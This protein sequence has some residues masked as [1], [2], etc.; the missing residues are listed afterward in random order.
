MTSTTTTTATAQFNPDRY[1][2]M[3]YRRCG[4]SGLMLPAFSIGGWHNFTDRDNVVEMMTAAFDLGITHVDLANN[5]G[6]PPGE[7]ETQVGDVLRREFKGHRDELIISSKAGYRMWPGPYGDLGSKK[8]LI[9]SLDQSLQR[10]GLEYVDIFYHHRFDPHTPL[11]ETMGALDLIVKQGKALYVGVSNYRGPAI[12]E[13]HHQLQQRGTALTIHQPSYSMFNRTPEHDV[14]PHTGR[15]GVGV[16]AFSP[17]AQ[18][19][20]SDKYLDD[21]PAD[22]RAAS[23]TGFLQRDRITPELQVQLHKLN[24]VARERGQSLSQMAL[25]WL[26]RDERVTSVLFGASRVSQIEANVKSLDAAAFSAEELEK[27]DAILAE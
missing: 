4:R 15:L 23:P 9:A 17:L 5:Y 1:Q 18:G 10:L 3:H 13:A 27:L 26:L 7:A 2:R 20:L 6:P 14:L 25:Q 19:L 24:D 11:D 8:S 21:V 22:S 12:V 16:I